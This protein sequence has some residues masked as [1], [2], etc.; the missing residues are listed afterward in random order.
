MSAIHRALTQE[1]TTTQKVRTNKK[2][3]IQVESISSFKN[4]PKASQ[5]DQRWLNASF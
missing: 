4:Y 5:R 2:N 3:L 1:T